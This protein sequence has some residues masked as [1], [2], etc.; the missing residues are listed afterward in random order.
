MLSVTDR[1][2]SAAAGW[3]RRYLRPDDAVARA[4]TW[5]TM[6]TSLSKGVFFS[7]S[8]LFFTHVAGFSATTVGF[9]LTIAGAVAVPAAL[10][11]GYLARFVGARR[12]LLATTAGQGLALVA[13][14]LV[15]TPA[16]FVVVAC[17]A[18]GQQAMQRTALSTMIAESFTGP[19]RVE[20]RARLR[21]ITNAF[22]GVGTGLAAVAIVLDTK[23]AYLLAMLA[24]GALLIVSAFLLR[25]MDRGAELTATDG[26]RT[27]GVRQS[28]L[29]DRTYLAITGLYAVMSMQVGMLTVGVPLWIAGSTK[30]PAATIAALLALNTVI[31]SLLQVWAARGAKAIR[32]AGRA[33]A[34]AGTLLALA[35]GL[36]AM[37]AHGAIAVVVVVLTLATVAH[38][39][40]EILSEAGSWTLAFELADPANVGAYQGVSQTGAAL[41]SMLAPLVV[42]ATAIQHGLPG[43]ILLGVLFLLAGSLTMA[44]VRRQVNGSLLPG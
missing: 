23:L 19:D 15:H 44:L 11:A 36:Y 10:G 37:A 38:S 27:A 26:S 28:P 9:G 16:T 17:A 22:I 7:V 43:W 31:V 30:A 21:V 39:L 4:L 40:A 3:V 34:W 2:W 12:V 6:T 8:V 42:T 29:R 20:M 1:H 5:A 32:S 35:C 13:Y 33:V 14:L 18:V 41:G 25:R 24:T